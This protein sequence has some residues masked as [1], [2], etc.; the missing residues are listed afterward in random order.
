MTGRVD[1]RADACPTCSD[2]ALPARVLRLTGSG[3]AIVQVERAEC[4]GSAEEAE[5]QVS[6]ALVDAEPGDT[7]LVHAKE[8]I[9]VIAKAGGDG[10][11]HGHDDG[12]G[13]G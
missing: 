10:H 5:E 9:A 2:E 1:P 11:D 12:Q 13:H 7:I 3:L 4:S 6:V 8:A